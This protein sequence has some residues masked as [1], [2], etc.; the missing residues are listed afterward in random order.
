MRLIMMGT[1]PFAV[2]SLPRFV[3]VAARSFGAVYASA[4]PA[5]WQEPGRGK[6]DGVA[7]EHGTPVHEPESVNADEARSVLAAYQSDLMVVCDYGQILDRRPCAR[8]G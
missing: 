2:P 1:G 8:L 5:A 3:H 6:S 7:L 4:A